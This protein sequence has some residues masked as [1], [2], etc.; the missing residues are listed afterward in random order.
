MP[1]HTWSAR[2]AKPTCSRPA[3][4]AGA[5]KLVPR[6]RSCCLG[7]H[8][9]SQRS[10]QSRRRSIVEVRP[11]ERGPQRIRIHL[12]QRT[13]GCGR[14]GDRLEMLTRS[15]KSAAVR[16]MD[17]SCSSPSSASDQSPRKSGSL[18]SEANIVARRGNRWPRPCHAW[19]CV[20]ARAR[21][22]ACVSQDE[23]RRSSASCRY[24][25][26]KTILAA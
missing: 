6:Q 18:S 9:T 22:W 7:P 1:E 15:C 11:I 5:A 4:K 12:T 16:S 19:Q 13:A 14:V 21:V 10:R 2:I 17:A 24:M 25:A 23:G 8:K 20:C 26:T 3:S